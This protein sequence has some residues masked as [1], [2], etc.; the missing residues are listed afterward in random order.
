MKE[1]VGQI[2]LQHETFT[3]KKSWSI[4]EVDKGLQ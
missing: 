2:D 3:T 1:A 4:A